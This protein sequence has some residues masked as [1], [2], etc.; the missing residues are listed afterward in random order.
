MNVELPKSRDDAPAA[1]LLARAASALSDAD[2]QTP[3][4][5]VDRL[6]GQTV[7]EDLLSY[8]P[9]DLAALA[10]RAFAFLAERSPGVPKIRCA[11]VPLPSRE[12]TSAWILEIVN[13]DMPFLLDSV[14]GELAE[15]RIAVRL[16]A[17]PVLRVSRDGARLRGI[18]EGERESLIHLHLDGLR[19]KVNA[20]R[21]RPRLRACF[22]R[23]ASRS[24]IGGRC[25]SA[26]MRSSAN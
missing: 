15:R 7:P 24:P 4:S 8:A 1:D 16:V 18:G 9:E 13:D 17:H 20:P 6:Y 21:S 22:V 12:R 26:S 10:A 14:M 2:P 3:P 25:W 11:S 19:T 5:F 23:C